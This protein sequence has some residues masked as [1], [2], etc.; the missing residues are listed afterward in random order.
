MLEENLNNIMLLLTCYGDEVDD[1][2]FKSIK[3]AEPK[4]LAYFC[5]L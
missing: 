1:Y 4:D 5:D 3:K 2:Q